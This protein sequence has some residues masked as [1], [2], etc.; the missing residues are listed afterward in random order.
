[1]QDVQCGFVAVTFIGLKVERSI[2]NRKTSVFF[3]AGRKT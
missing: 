2:G 1:M 3:S